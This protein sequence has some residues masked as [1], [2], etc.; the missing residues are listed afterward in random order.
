MYNIRNGHLLRLPAAKSTSYVRNSN[1]FRACI[2]WNSLSQNVKYSETILEK[3]NER[4]R[5]Y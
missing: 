5:K 3:R 2:L 4:S 1:L